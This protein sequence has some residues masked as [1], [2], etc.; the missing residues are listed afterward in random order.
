M[1]RISFVFQEA[2]R[3]LLYNKFMTFVV[4]VNIAISLYFVSV[5]LTSFLNLNKIIEQAEARVTLEVFLS[6]GKVDTALVRSEIMS[7][8]GV[9]GVRYISKEEA[10]EIFIKEVG[11]DIM[12]SVEGNP[13]P[14]SYKCSIEAE[15]RNQEKLSIMRNSLKG[16]ASVDEVS[17]I[18]GWVPV[19]Q[20]VRRIFAGISLGVLGILCLTIFFTVFSTIRLAY[21]SRHEHIRVMALV[22]ASEFAIK[23]PFIISGGIQG[24]C[25]GALSAIVLYVSIIFAKRY[26]ST[27]YFDMRLVPFLMGLGLFLGVLA[28]FRSIPAEE[29]L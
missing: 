25:G 24:F 11:S 15:Y 9:S 19:L 13:L 29:H 20:K 8:P 21:Q 28:S 26:I 10:Y 16:I 2:L 12:V 3:G 23:V 17:E 27:M 1:N 6:D 7:T 4:I 14:A 22:G 18:R 5:F